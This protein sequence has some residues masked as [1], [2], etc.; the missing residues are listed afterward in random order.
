MDE[1]LQP[2]DLPRRQ[3]PSA[4]PGWYPLQGEQRY[5]DGLQWTEHRQVRPYHAGPYVGPITDART[6]GAEVA[7]AWVFT[8]F[9]LGYFLPW[10]IAATRGK[11]NSLLIGLINFLVGWTVIGWVAAL[12]MAC[13]AHQVIAVTTFPRR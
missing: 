10:A 8:V 5:W 12:V 3:E 4:P 7:F 1:D 11:S 2:Y 9:T 13:L 6:N